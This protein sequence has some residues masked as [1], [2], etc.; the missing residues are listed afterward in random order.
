[1]I[2]NKV[3]LVLQEGYGLDT[4]TILEELEKKIYDIN[5]LATVIHTVR[6]QVDLCK[7]L[8]RQAYGAKV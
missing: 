5:S 2:L 7:I 1:M 6:C 3:D 4:S 8:D